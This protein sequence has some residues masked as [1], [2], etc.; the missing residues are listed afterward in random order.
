MYQIKT[1]LTSES[2]SCMI[3]W[4]MKESMSVKLA[5]F[6]SIFCQVSPSTAYYLYCN[7]NMLS[8]SEEPRRVYWKCQGWNL[9]PCKPWSANHSA[10]LPPAFKDLSVIVSLSRAL[11]LKALLEFNHKGVVSKNNLI[12]STH[13]WQFRSETPCTPKVSWAE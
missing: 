11:P 9:A 4:V 12:T 1:T 2:A 3:T 6:Q 7:G 5:C 13:T 10:T 8:M